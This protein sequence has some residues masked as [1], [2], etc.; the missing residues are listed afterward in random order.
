MNPIKYLIG[1]RSELAQVV[2]PKPMEVI[3]LTALVIVISAVVGVYVGLLD[4]GFTK[5]IGLIISK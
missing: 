3:K 5:L 1:V 2:W 4:L